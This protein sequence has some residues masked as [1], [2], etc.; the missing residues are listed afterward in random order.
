MRY[1]ASIIKQCL[2]VG[3]GSMEWR[4]LTWRSPTGR[5]QCWRTCP[6]ASPVNAYCQQLRGANLV[7]MLA[8]PHVRTCLGAWLKVCRLMALLRISTVNG[9]GPPAT[10]AAA[11]AGAS[12]AMRRP[13][14]LAVDTAAAWRPAA[15]WRSP[16]GACGC[17]GVTQEGSRRR[18]RRLLVLKDSLGEIAGRKDARKLRRGCRAGWRRS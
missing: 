8:V 6:F 9:M 14:R 10:A 18:R 11:A 4:L 17:C 2:P 16:R 5:R 7:F 12:P 3:R 15:T 13:E 1:L